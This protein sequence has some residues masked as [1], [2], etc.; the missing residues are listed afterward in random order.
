MLP[1]F[2]ERCS[3]P[4]LVGNCRGYFKNYYYDNERQTCVPF[5]YGGCGGN[6][7]RFNTVEEC[8]D[9]CHSPGCPDHERRNLPSRLIDWFHVLRAN[10]IEKE[11]KLKGNHQQP[12]L[13]E[14]NFV[15]GKLKAMYS[16]LAC[17]DNDDEV[18]K[19]VC[20]PPVRWMFGDLDKDNDQVLSAVELLAIEEVNNEH[21]IKPFLTSCDRNK[22]KKV[23]LKEFCRCLCHTPPC[24]HLLESI[25]TV[26]I[27]GLARPMPGKFTPKCDE[28]GFFM[29]RQV[30][31]LKEQHWCVDRNGAEF[32]GTRKNISEAI[33]CSLNTRSHVTHGT[34]IPLNVQQ[35]DEID[36]P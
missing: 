22:D 33:E 10:E 34:R 26:V 12:V 17:A 6:D 8:M 14:I 24:T 31:I 13:K 30:N 20:L 25:P 11:N 21:C 15:D 19:E 32:Q 5:V 4:K 18:E 35:E 1:S 16:R 23:V 36:K 3:Q 29:P 7:N 2:I 9:T 27:N 28:D